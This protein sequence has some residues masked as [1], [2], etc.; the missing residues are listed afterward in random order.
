M[1]GTVADVADILGRL[2]LGELADRFAAEDIDTTV[3][4]MLDDADLRELGLTLGQRRKLLAEIA[5]MRP[6]TEG[7]S[8]MPAPKPVRPAARDGLELRRLTVAI[9]DMVG[10]TE[11][12]AR[13]GP[14]EMHDVLQAYYR[15]ARE[16]AARHGGHFQPLQGDGAILLFGYPQSRGATAERAV[17]AALQ[18]QA[19][20]ASRPH[21]LSDGSTVVLR[22]RIGVA[23]GKLMVGYAPDAGPHDGLQIVGNAVNRAAR[24]QALADPGSVIADAPTAKLAAG[25]A[26]EDLPAARLKGFDEA[27]AVVRVIGRRIAPPDLPAPRVALESAHRAEAEALALAWAEARAGAAALAIV[28]G[29]AGIGKSTLLAQVQARAVA[30]GARVLRLACSALGANTPLGPVVALV[31]AVAAAGGAEG[32]LVA[33][34]ERLF[35]FADA[36]ERDEVAALLGLGTEG[37]APTRPSDRGRLLGVLAARMIDGAGRPSLIVVEDLHWADAST[38]D[39]L[40]ACGQRAD[41]QG[42]MILGSSRKADEALWAHDPRRR[43]VNLSPLGRDAVQRVLKQ[44][45][46]ARVLPDAITEVILARCD[47]NPLMVDALARRFEAWTDAELRDEM[48]VP[49]SIYES[50]S[51]RVDGLAKGNALAEALSVFDAPAAEGTLALA[52]ELGAADLAEA[53]AELCAAG[54]TEWV[55]DGRQRSLAFC[56]SLYREVIYERMVRA[57]RQRLHRSAYRALLAGD[58]ALAEEMPAVLAWHAGEGGDFAQAA[59]LALRAG[60]AALARS[61]LIEAGHHFDRA[62]AALERVARSRPVD[63]LRLRALA[64]MASVKR[65]REGIASDEAGRLG[66][67]VLTLARDLGETRTELLALNGLYSHALVRADYRAAGAWAQELDHAA[68]QAQDATFRMIATRA[69]GVVALHTGDPRT[70][71]ELLQRALDAYDRERHVALAFAHG[72]DHAEICAVF[73]SFSLWLEGDLAGSARVG[74]F[75]V[76]HSREIDHAHSLAQ[77][78][79]FRA[80]L[81]SLARDEAGAIAA[82]REGAEVGARFDL[83]AMHGVGEFLALAAA[84]VCAGAPVSK[85][86]LAEL[87]AKHV[88]FREVNPFNY[89]PMSLSLMAEAELLAGDLDAVAATVAEA[90]S[91]QEQNAEIWTRPEVTRIKAHL[92]LARG[93]REAALALLHAG[94]EDA[95]AMG[96]VVLE[97]RLATELALLAPLDEAARARVLAALARL[98]SRDAGWDVSRAQAIVERVAV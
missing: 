48:E 7:V 72:Y 41:G 39:L 68:A 40:E 18:L 42:V 32:D 33:A 49:T 55:G 25:F 71:A 23:T 91:V 27:V 56:H 79:T 34:L 20:L 81:L 75:S 95:A 44:V 69:M 83:R 38:R 11:L 57:A 8:E 17:E 73:L 87:R 53:A 36:A 90:E 22:A 35:T 78:L 50:I 30:D 63:M 93:E 12:A 21:G 84:L 66:R 86:A 67:A 96:S 52:V 70:G 65:A 54:M 37:A 58:P 13:L 51:A 64:G 74:A 10:S 89:L 60:E 9:A 16:V 94:V 28:T 31:R 76:S 59:P 61:A 97:L 43:L 2:G 4:L 80:M 15:H 77:A 47:G 85:E 1:V 88:R 98:G 19:E 29:D 92:A 14:D 62:L 5:R 82:A 45:L 3:F 24:L 6:A 46:G 26:V